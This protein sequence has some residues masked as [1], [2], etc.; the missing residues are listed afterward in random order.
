MTLLPAAAAEAQL[1]SNV[2]AQASSMATQSGPITSKEEAV[3]RARRLT[4]IP[5]DA[6]MSEPQYWDSQAGPAWR[7]SF[8]QAGAA[9]GGNSP[10]R[11]EISLSGADGSLLMLSSTKKLEATAPDADRIAVSFEEASEIARSYID[12]LD[13]GL[14]TEWALDPYPESEYSTRGQDKSLHKLRFQRIV[15]GIPFDQN[16]FTVWVNA[17]G[18]VVSYDV[19][20]SASTFAEPANILSLQ[21]AQVKLLEEADLVLSYGYIADGQPRPVYTLATSIMD[22]VDGSYPDNRNVPNPYP[23]SGQMKP[24]SAEILEPLT[25]NGI[26]SEVTQLARIRQVLGLADD[27]ALELRKQDISSGIYMVAYPS[28]T[29][30]SLREAS[31]IVDNLTG[32]LD[33]FQY[34]DWAN[35]SWV[36]EPKVSEQEAK[37]KAESFL[38]Q[39]VPAYMNQLAHYKTELTISKDNTT[40]QPEY[41][42]EYI[43]VANGIP[44]RNQ[45]VEVVVHAYTGELMRMNAH[46]HAAAYPPDQAPVMSK[47]KARRLLL[48]LYDVRVTYASERVFEAKLYYELMLKPT[49]PRFYTGAAPSLDSLSGEWRN[50]IGEPIV[51]PLPPPESGNWVEELLSSPEYIQYTAGVVMDDVPLYLVHEPVIRDGSTLVPVRELLE[52]MGAEVRWDADTRQIIIAKGSTRIEL[53]LDDAAAVMNGELHQLE[54]PAQLVDSSTYIP[55]RAVAEALGAKVEWEAESR[56]IRIGTNGELS[57]PTEASLRQWRLEHQRH[58]EATGSRQA[59]ER[60]GDKTDSKSSMKRSLTAMEALRLGYEEAKRHTD[61]EPLLIHMT[62]I[63]DTALQQV[64]S[65]GQ[66]GKRSAWSLSFGSAKGNIHIRIAIRNGE[67][68]VDRVAKDD[69]NSLQKGMYVISDIHIDSSRAVQ[70][71]IEAM[72]MRPGDPEVADDWM[73]GYHFEIAGF[74]TA[75]HSSS[76]RL[77]LRVIGISPNSPGRMGESLRMIVFFDG[78]TGEMLNASDMTGY[79]ENGRTMWREVE[80]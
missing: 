46:L 40:T 16:R 68:S 35:Y 12:G 57:L 72:G 65:D 43:R 71:S 1:A 22:A 19:Y 21:E 74:H 54:V 51:G 53:K 26:A 18:S 75:P 31:L 62:S 10:F 25:S 23:S 17:V 78:K 9:E 66:D 15:N 37:A 7:I 24:L 4:W 48:S 14:D 38:R 3:E 55:I 52:R 34:Y 63:D 56:L 30:G 50:Y 8:T 45:L 60:S 5:S 42:M 79:D 39:A 33:D 59:I 77:M 2:E 27:D 41:R 47:E 80:F 70:R 36:T 32:Q 64:R 29:D 76:T 11:L 61:E 58:W 49:V 20:W 28:K 67:L 6:V 69:T 13:L 73:K 44:F